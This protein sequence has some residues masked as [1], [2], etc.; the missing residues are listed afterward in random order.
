MEIRQ[1]YKIVKKLV[2]RRSKGCLYQAI[3]RTTGEQVALRLIDVK[4]SNAGLDDGIPTT[5]LRE[6]SALKSISHENIV[7]IVDAQ[8]TGHKV[9]I[10]T[11]FCKYNMRELMRNHIPKVT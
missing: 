2:E 6:I 1:K 9:I 4:I 5:I 3:S 11:K 8:I 7:D 10:I